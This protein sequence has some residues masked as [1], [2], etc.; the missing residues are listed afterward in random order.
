MYDNCPRCGALGVDVGV[1][2]PICSGRG[3]SRLLALLR[4]VR[5]PSY[6]APMTTT[7]ATCTHPKTTWER[8]KCRRARAAVSPAAQTLIDWVAAGSDGYRPRALRVVA[9]RARIDARDMTTTELAVALTSD[10]VT[11]HFDQEVTPAFVNR[12]NS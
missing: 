6:G 5:V 7:H 3:G 4:L 1:H 12:I 11:R 9:R 10:A 2:M 8:A